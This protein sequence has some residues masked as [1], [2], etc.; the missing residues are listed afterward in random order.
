MKT[1]PHLQVLTDVLQKHTEGTL[2]PEDLPDTLTIENKELKL[3]PPTGA[4]I[5]VFNKALMS[6]GD[7]MTILT[8]AIDKQFKDI[9]TKYKIKQGD[10]YEY[11]T[12]E[13]LG[14]LKNPANILYLR[15]YYG[16]KCL[17]LLCSSGR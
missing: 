7:D 15:Y 4:D 13:E 11:L 2:V 17:F 16:A 8:E 6:M 5:V 3:I 10:D 14:L 1:I 9:H 12:S